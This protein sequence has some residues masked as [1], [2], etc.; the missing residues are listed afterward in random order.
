VSLRGRLLAAFAYLLVLTVVA[1]AVP[2]AVTVDRRAKDTFYAGIDSQTQVIA[3]SL[4]G[5]LQPG[6][7]LPGVRRAVAVYGRETDARVI[8]T[9]RQ[10]EL[11]AD[12]QRAAPARVPFDTTGRPEIAAALAGRSV[13]LIRR[14]AD[15]GG[16]L[17][18]VAYPIL[19]RGRV[20]GAVRLS[21]PIATVDERVHRS[22][23][24]IA[25]VAAAVVLVGLAVAWFLA[26]SL[27]QP[28]NSLGAT[29]ARLGRGD[30]EARAP[31][32]GPTD[33]ADVARAMNRMADELVGLIESQ[34]EFVGNASHQLRT[35]LT[36]MRLRLEA[37]AAGPPA[38]ADAEA[39]LREV[40]RLADLVS[41]LL[42]L[43]R[44]GVPPHAEAVC[45]LRG[46]ARAAADRW[47][48][49]AAEHGN[50]FALEEPAGPIHVAAD[51]AD[52]AVV[53]DNLIENAIVYTPS[54]GAVSVAV[55]EGGLVRVKDEG[56]GIDPAEA[57][58]VFDRFFR[59]SAGSSAPGG[60]GLGLAIVRD[61]A[62]RWGGTVKLEPVESGTSIAVR[63]PAARQ[64][65]AVADS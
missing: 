62:A 4:G 45:D 25:A 40:D 34:R 47:R 30:L 24:A 42:V 26:R 19:D 7:T 64:A 18:V 15:L 50:T 39:G 54:G 9:D 56:P 60:T 59:G 55:D 14:S 43:A 16:S 10:G 20:I 17:L 63:F 21:Q 1:L 6:G 61:L 58:R 44:A 49:V 52:V 12:S 5:S 33:V 31:E 57:A 41:D 46:Q 22:W 35:P 2:L 38:N 32:A 28:I 48:P 51:A 3:A 27:T 23:L 11:L 36:G 53:L 29:A 37:I 13:S 8:V 65:P